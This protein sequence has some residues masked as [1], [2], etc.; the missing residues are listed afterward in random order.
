MVILSNHRLNHL[1]LAHRELAVRWR[2]G[3]WTRHFGDGQHPPRG[4]LH[5][6]W[7]PHRPEPAS[8][9]VS[10]QTA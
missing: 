6:L 10:G 1:V 3:L 8:A 5:A 7:P 2:V 4:D 9:G